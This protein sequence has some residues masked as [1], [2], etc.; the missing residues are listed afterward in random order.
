MSMK[1]FQILL[2]VAAVLCAAGIAPTLFGD[3]TTTMPQ[4]FSPP[5][6]IT[7][8]EG[9]ASRPPTRRGGR[10]QGELAPPAILDRRTDSE[11]GS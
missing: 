7:A 3:R 2:V 6:W 4:N 10:V 9:I 8:F 1:A 5:G 11:S